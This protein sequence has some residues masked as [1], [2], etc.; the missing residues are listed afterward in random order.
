MEEDDGIL[1]NELRQKGSLTIGLAMILSALTIYTIVV[2]APLRLVEE[3]F[4]P[5]QFFL[6]VLWLISTQKIVPVEKDFLKIRNASYGTIQI[7][8]TNCESSGN[9]IG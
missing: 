3:L 8:W 2:P 5:C 4:L 9:G 1:D 6:C 7:S